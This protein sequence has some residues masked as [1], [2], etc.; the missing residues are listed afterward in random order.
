MEKIV[1]RKKQKGSIS[2]FILLSAL[3]FVATVTAVCVSII[4]KK[5]SIDSNFSKI[6]NSY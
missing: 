1:K 4:N 5:S 3:F 6:K 2:L